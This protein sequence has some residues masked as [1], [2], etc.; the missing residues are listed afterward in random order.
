MLTGGRRPPGLAKG[1]FVEPTI[2]TDVSHDMTVWRE[3]V[4]RCRQLCAV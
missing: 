3:E 4:Q 1:F 2:F